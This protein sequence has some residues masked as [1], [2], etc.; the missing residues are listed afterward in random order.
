MVHILSE[1]QL[2]FQDVLLK[3]RPS[4]LKSRKDV[5]LSKRYSDRK[6][7]TIACGIP[8]MNANMSTVG[9]FAV[10]R[11]M[12]N[13][14]MF[15]T[16]HKHYQ[17]KEIVEFMKSIGDDQ[18]RRV[19]ISIGIRDQFMNYEKLK[20]IREQLKTEGFYPGQICIDVPNA[21]LEIVLDLVK[22]VRA[23]SPSALIM[24]GNVCSPDGVTD[25]AEAGAHIIKVGVGSSPACRT[26]FVAGVGRP[27]L[28]AIIACAESAKD[29]NCVICSDGGISQPADVVKAIAAGVEFV[30]CGSFYAGTEEAEG[31]FVEYR[32]E[33][34]KVYYGMASETAQNLFYGGVDDYKTSEGAL[35][36][37]NYQGYVHDQN[38]KIMGGLRS[39]CTYLNAENLSELAQNAI[40]YK[41]RRQH[42]I[43]GDK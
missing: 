9:N 27:Q 18:A 26:R 38:L 3:P 12:L 30:M 35:L 4:K 6:G 34:C 1:E 41:V 7:L 42:T 25:L 22:R 16:I 32:G 11:A 20:A 28:S 23:E 17:P 33:K 43:K 40:F 14:G 15:A 8:I 2:D 13:D 5:C 31:E 37:V 36:Y 29:H 19:F 39:A 10:A 24:A 21:Y